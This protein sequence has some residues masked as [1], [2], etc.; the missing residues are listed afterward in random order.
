M[1]FLNRRVE[2]EWWQLVHGGGPIV[3]VMVYTDH[4]SVIETG[5]D[6]LVS[7]IIRT[8]AEQ[9]QICRTLSVDYY[10]SVHQLKRGFDLREDFYADD[11]TKRICDRVNGEFDYGGGRVVLALHVKGTARHLHGQVPVG[12]HWKAGNPRY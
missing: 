1:R 11:Q 10:I 9:R 12:S 8:E 2:R 5:H 7:G 6:M 4:A 3:P